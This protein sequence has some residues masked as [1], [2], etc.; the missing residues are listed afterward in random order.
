MNDFNS[1]IRDTP[2]PSIMLQFN[3]DAINDND[4]MFIAFYSQNKLQIT[5]YSTIINSNINIHSPTQGIKDQS[6]TTK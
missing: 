6:L 3:E 2:I 5:I 4:E 1:R